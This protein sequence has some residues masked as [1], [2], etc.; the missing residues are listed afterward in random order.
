MLSESVVDFFW[1]NIKKDFENNCWEWKG[2]KN[3]HGYGV[4]YSYSSFK[5]Y[6]H[7]RAHRVSWEIYNAEEIPNGLY[8][9][10]HCDNPSCVNPNHLFLG[11]QKDNILD[12]VRKGRFRR[13]Y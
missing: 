4:I 12:S 2:A 1:A 5:K 8:I 11:T 6:A 9:C 13:R 10:H 3:R 7:L